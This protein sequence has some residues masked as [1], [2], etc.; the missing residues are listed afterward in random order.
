[1]LSTGT[2]S[3]HSARI[4]QVPKDPSK[5][6]PFRQKEVI[7]QIKTRIAGLQ[8]NQYDIQCVNKVYG[9]KNRSEYFYKGKIQG[10][11]TQYSPA[12]VVWLLHQYSKD[13]TFFSK[14]KAKAK[15]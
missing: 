7:E 3:I 9:I 4:I 10:S 13:K 1:M 12:F 14:A 2:E 5:S 6:H 15:V 8:V 11:P